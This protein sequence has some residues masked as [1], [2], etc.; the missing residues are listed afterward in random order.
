MSSRSRGDHLRRECRG[1]SRYGGYT[2]SEPEPTSDSGVQSE[3]GE[4]KDVVKDLRSELN[5]VAGDIE[6]LSEGN[7]LDMSDTETTVKDTDGSVASDPRETESSK[8]DGSKVRSKCE[9]VRE[10]EHTSATGGASGSGPVSKSRGGERYSSGRSVSRHSA[11]SRRSKTREGSGQSSVA[12][13]SRDRVRRVV[14][15]SESES[16]EEEEQPESELEFVEEEE[17]SPI[18]HSRNIERLLEALASTAVESK[19]NKLTD[20]TMREVQSIASFRDG[21]E[22][23]SYIMGLES[24]LTDIGVPKDKWKRI[25]LR[26]LTPKA[27]KTLRGYVVEASCSYPELKSAL[28]KKLGMHRHAVTEKLFGISDRELRAMDPVARFIHL[29]DYM[30]RLMLNLDS[31]RELPLAVVAGIFRTSLTTNEKCML[32]SRDILSFEDLYD[33]AELIKADHNPKHYNDK[34]RSSG[35]HNNN[36]TFKCFKCQGVGHRASECKRSVSDFV[37]CN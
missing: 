23:H 7:T 25:F 16:E 14:E 36:D 35:R 9:A 37:V 33:V 19:R 10:P 27:R 30:D 17:Y 5:C 4:G 34:G 20:Y 26:K 22:I 18:S 6:R 2:D 15:P 8:R 28:V 29:R 31:T 24:D 13:R 11:V 21:D 3:L 1:K 32:D 12:R